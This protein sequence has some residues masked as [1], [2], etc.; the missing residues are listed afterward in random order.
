MF[1]GDTLYD[2]FI[3]DAS[4][5][6]G[7]PVPIIKGIIAQE[8]Q[9]N[10]L[11]TRQEVGDTSTGL[12]QLLLSTARGLGYTG[13]AA[14]LYEPA[15]NI[16]LGTHLIANLWQELGDWGAVFSAYNGGIRPEIAMGARASRVITGVC[17]AKDARGNCLTKVNVQPGQFANQPYVDAV[18]GYVGQYAGAPLVDLTDPAAGSRGPLW[19][20][21]AV[22]AVGLVFMFWQADKPRSRWD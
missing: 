19:P 5:K 16:D 4:S 11:A 1:P 15:V 13:T 7:V 6:W 8:S 9:F 21:L 18:A 3:A 10:P 20:F 12:M 14:G 17:L 22:A 2:S